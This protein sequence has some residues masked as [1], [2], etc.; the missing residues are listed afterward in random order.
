MGKRK[1][2]PGQL[3]LDLDWGFLSRLS[4][5]GETWSCYEETS[6][7]FLSDDKEKSEPSRQ[8]YAPNQGVA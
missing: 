1:K 8:P 7:R 2:I 6:K 5:Y 4:D 3:H